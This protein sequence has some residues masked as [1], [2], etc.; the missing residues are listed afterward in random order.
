MSFR[1]YDPILNV[2]D[3]LLPNSKKEYFNLRNSMNLTRLQQDSFTYKIKEKLGLDSNNKLT[4][5]L[6]TKRTKSPG[7]IHK[8]SEHVKC[9]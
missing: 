5:A 7:F 2:V 9:I 3:E 8:D 1:F 4:P 6:N